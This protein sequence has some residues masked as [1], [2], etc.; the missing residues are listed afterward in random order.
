MNEYRMTIIKETPDH[1][2]FAIIYPW[3][4]MNVSASYF[5]SAQLSYTKTTGLNN[6]LFLCKVKGV[7]YDLLIG[8]CLKNIVF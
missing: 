8:S 2:Y 4:T 6:Q 7:K 3:A 5:E 1:I